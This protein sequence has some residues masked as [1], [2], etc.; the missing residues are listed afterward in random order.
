ME[1]SKVIKRKIIF[2]KYAKRFVKE[3][4]KVADGS[5]MDWYYLDSPKSV[6]VVPIT[7]D[8]KLILIRQFRY[9]LKK[10]V[11][12]FPAGFFKDPDETSFLSAAKIELQEE[13]GYKAKRYID[14][15]SYYNLPS[16][17]NRWTKIYLALYATKKSE[18]KLDD[19]IEKYFDI[20]VK[21]EDYNKVIKNLTKKGSLIEGSEHVLA[22]MLPRA[23]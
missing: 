12:E 21:L 19:I 2:H 7:P 13:T 3:T 8:G 1:N 15:G 11:Y 17:T 4:L 10:H 6:V 23:F 20:S 9:N 18:P 16:E 5:L 14:L 22:N